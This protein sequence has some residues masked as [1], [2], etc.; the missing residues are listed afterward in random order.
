MMELL[1]RLFNK[2]PKVDYKQLVESDAQIIDVRTKEEFQNG[3]IPGSINI[4]LQILGN[5]LSRIQKDVPVI[6]CCA[7]GIRSGSATSMLRSKGFTNVYNGGAWTSLQ[8]KI[9]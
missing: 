2:G 3:H 5:N 9:R 7:S 6:L 1:K 8:N 4:P